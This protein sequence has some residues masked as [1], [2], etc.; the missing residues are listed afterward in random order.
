MQPILLLKNITAGYGEIQVLKSVTMHIGV[1]E[2]VTLIGSNGAGKT[3]LINVISGIIKP[4]KG[5]VIFDGKAIHKLMPH[6]IVSMGILQVPEGRQIFAPLTVY[7]NLLLGTY[8]RKDCDRKEI[9]RDLEFVYSL[10]PILKERRRQL[11]GTLSGGEQQMLA[12]GRALMARPRVLLLD[13]PSLG[14]APKLVD[15]IMKTI[16]DLNKN[17][18][19]ILLVEQNAR[20]ALEISHRGYVLDTGRII[21]HGDSKTLMNDPDVQRAY[22]GKEYKN[23]SE[24]V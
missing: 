18:I 16:C 6:K 19:T 2:T 3:T 21:L 1:G 8:T 20:K 9:E 17:G 11:A 4:T 22:L 7:D 12:I 23:I 15:L 5:E 13:E 24:R 10:F 14:L